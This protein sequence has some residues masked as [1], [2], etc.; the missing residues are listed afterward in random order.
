MA[1]R[2]QR[3]SDGPKSV[4]LAD[5]I[6]IA[7]SFCRN[8]AHKVTLQPIEKSPWVI[9]GLHLQELTVHQRALRFTAPTH[10]LASP[11]LELGRKLKPVPHHQAN[12]YRCLPACATPNRLPSLKP[13]IF[14]LQ[15][16]LPRLSHHPG[17]HPIRPSIL[18]NPTI[19]MISDKDLYTLSIFLGS[20]AMLLIVLYHFLEVNADDNTNAELNADLKD[21]KSGVGA[22]KPRS[23]SKTSTGTGV[24]VGSGSGSGKS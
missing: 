14:Y 7:R 15:Q 2:R 20:C 1:G 11:H 21:E 12:H 22:V 10:H 19:K 8:H 24:G 4:L 18:T 13:H 3:S 9:C 5:R 17:L 16:T 23:D 6:L